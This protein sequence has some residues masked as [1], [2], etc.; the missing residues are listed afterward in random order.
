MTKLLHVMSSYCAMYVD[1]IRLS[2]LA[3]SNPPLYARRM[4]QYMIPAIGLFTLPAQMQ[5]YLL[6]TEE[7]PHFIEPKYDSF[8]Y[9]VTQDQTSE[10]VV[11]LGENY[12]GYELFSCAIRQTDE[13][14]DID[15]IPVAAAY[16]EETGTVTIPASVSS[17]IPAGTVLEMDFYTDGEFTET[18]SV[19]IQNILGLC[20]QVVW[21]ERFNTDW[22][23]MVSKAED[24][25]F[26]EQNRA[27]KMR[28]DTERL[29]M[30]R[31]KLAGEMR[32]LE[33]NTYY[34]TVIRQE[35][36]LG[37]GSSGSFSGFPKYEG[38]YQVTP[39]VDEQILPTEKKLMTD[40]LT[41]EE[42]PIYESSNESGRT[43]IIGG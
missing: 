38:S 27:N 36:S 11:S 14:G 24:K 35:V 40:D 30:L 33:Q 6:G 8:S 42:I 41:V 32:R 17:P 7:D 26:Y 5:I 12:T 18:L 10:I 2:N 3:V 13:T 22:L 1:D 25:S 43:I 23:S 28:A 20:F 9:T 29:D 39:K 37:S 4:S 15:D 31:R 19:Q 21:Q 16:D 34:N